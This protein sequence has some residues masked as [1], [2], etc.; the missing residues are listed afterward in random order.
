V[1]T[2][3]GVV[4]DGTAHIQQGHEAGVMVADTFH[5]SDGVFVLVQSACALRIRYVV[6]AVSDIDAQ[7]F[8]GRGW[9]IGGGDA[10]DDVRIDCQR[11]RACR[12]AYAALTGHCWLKSLS[13][14][15]TTGP[16][17]RR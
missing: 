7:K 5:S 17:G 12:T 14:W 13:L 10:H 3:V 1:Q 11:R 4:V 9:G 8:M 16:H 2:S 15:H 6:T